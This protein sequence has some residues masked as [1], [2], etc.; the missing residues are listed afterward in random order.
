MT[1]WAA[2]LDVIDAG[3]QAS[4]PAFLDALPADLGPIP[5][6]LA[7]R[8]AGTLARMAEVEAALEQE[9]AEIARELSAL[10]AVKAPSNGSASP[11]PHFLDTKA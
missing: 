4:P 11:V 7:A 8:A 9:R 3:L 1:D 5:P 2:L 10:A 6:V